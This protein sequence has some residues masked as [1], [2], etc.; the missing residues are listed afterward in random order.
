M[1]GVVRTAVINRQRL[2]DWAHS[3]KPNTAEERVKPSIP[4]GFFWSREPGMPTGSINDA[5]VVLVVMVSAV[6]AV[7]DTA[8][9]G[10]LANWHAAPVGRPEQE[11]DTGAASC[12][13]G[14][15]VSA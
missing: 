6:V 10:L 4:P 2:V 15:N 14:V 7:A 5:E 11:N 9:S 12:P 8:G 3:P 13:V 1:V